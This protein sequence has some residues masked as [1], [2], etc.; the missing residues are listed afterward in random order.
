L[1]LAGLE[2]S[3]L[4]LEEAEGKKHYSSGELVVKY[5][6]LEAEEEEGYESVVV[7]VWAVKAVRIV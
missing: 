1:R 7:A 6:C 5:S 4:V 3:G 2:N